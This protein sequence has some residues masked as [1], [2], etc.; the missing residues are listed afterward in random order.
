MKLREIKAN[1]IGALVCVRGI[2]T[3]CSD[4]KPAMQVAVYACEACGNEVYQVVHGKEFTPLSQ[5][6]SQKCEKNQVKGNLNLQIK[7]SKFVAFQ[8][9]KIQEPSDQVPIGH[10]PRQMNLV[11]R[12]PLTRQCGPGDVV[13][14]TG[15]LLPS[16]A[17]RAGFRGSLRHSTHVECFEVYKQRQNF[18]SLNL[19]DEMERTVHELKASMS[20]EELFRR[21]ADSICPEIFGMED[22]KQALLLLMIGGV[23]KHMK[24]GM[25][26]RG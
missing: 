21:M 22:V 11:A 14:I 12:G 19:S 24:D 4:V 20:E 6:P 1:N 23:S 25:K 10:V 3:R 16:K 5:C 7:Q 17:E 18:R 9:I 13:T 26:I 2:V 8:E 15:V